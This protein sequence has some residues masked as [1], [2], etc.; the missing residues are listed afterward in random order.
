MRVKPGDRDSQLGG[1]K[2]INVEAFNAYS[3]QKAVAANAEGQFVNAEGK[4]INNI[5]HI[6]H[7]GANINI[8]CSGDPTKNDQQ[9]N[10]IFNH[11]APINLNFYEEVKKKQ[12][13]E[14]W[15]FV[16]TVWRFHLDRAKQGQGFFARFSEIDLTGDNA[17]HFKNDRVMYFQSQWFTKS[18]GRCL[19][20]IF[21]VT[22]MHTLKLMVSGEQYQ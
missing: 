11:T 5:M 1:Q 4:I 10:F 3:E 6:N 12:N 16:R 2:N 7:S 14:D 13:S 18:A 15:G 20:L 17:G 22:D 9:N 21:S 8:M 19:M